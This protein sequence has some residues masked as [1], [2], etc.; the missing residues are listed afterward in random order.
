MSF[1][2]D[3]LD[4]NLV[5]LEEK[6]LDSKLFDSQCFQFGPSFWPDIFVISRT[7]LSETKIQ[8]SVETAGQDKIISGPK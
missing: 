2:D 7:S 8:H 1:H 4:N 3:Q 5:F 6:L